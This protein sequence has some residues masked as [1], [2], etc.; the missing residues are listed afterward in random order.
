MAEVATSGNPGPLSAVHPARLVPPRELYAGRPALAVQMAANSNEIVAAASICNGSGLGAVITMPPGR[1]HRHESVS[2]A[3]TAFGSVTGDVSDVLVDANRY[4]GKNRTVGA[5]P[6]DVTWVDAQLDKGQRFA[7]TDS[8]YIPDGDFAALD[9]TL[10]QGRDM[11]RPV[12]VNLPISHLWLRNRST[13]LREAINRA[14]VPV[15]LTVEHRG[16]PMGGQGVVRGLVHALGAE[17]PVFLLRC[18]ASAIV[19][20]PYGAAGGAIGTSTRL[21]HLYPLPAPGSK[22]GGRPSRVAVWVP[23]LLAYM[24]LE[25]VADLVQYPDVD[26]H[27]VCDCTQCLGLGLDR[28]TN[29]AQAYEHSLRALTD[30]ATLRLGSQ[31]SPELQRKA[32]Y[33][34]GESAQFLHFDIE[35]S[36]GVR[37]EP[38]SF[39]GAWKRAYEQLNS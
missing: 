28:I 10:K 8:P 25:T 3:L 5:G 13:E 4:A 38:P 35:S 37:L 1:A 26:Q 22:S 7:L 34:A 15:A 2:A 12:I 9:S 20:I 14:G 24:S 32:F 31:R 27:F 18:D 21:R 36:T 39:L 33:A 30:F 19:A 6:L 17:Q 29:E 23:R 11:R 16:D